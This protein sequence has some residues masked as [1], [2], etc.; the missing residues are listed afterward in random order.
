MLVNLCKKSRYETKCFNIDHIRTY[1]SSIDASLS[2]THEI[3]CN[4]RILILNFEMWHHTACIGKSCVFQPCAFQIGSCP[5]ISPCIG[6][7]SFHSISLCIWGKS[8]QL[9]NRF[10]HQLLWQQLFQLW[11]FR[12]QL[13]QQSTGWRMKAIVTFGAELMPRKVGRLLSNS[14]EV[15]EVTC[16]QSPPRGSMTTSRTGK[17]STQSGLEGLTKMRRVFGIGWTAPLF[18]IRHSQRGLTISP[19]MEEINIVWSSRLRGGMITFATSRTT[20]CAPRDCARQVFP[21]EHKWPH[22]GLP[23]MWGQTRSQL[24]DSIF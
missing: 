4:D 18:E 10:Q 23:Y 13:C 5:R 22:L 2:Y 17:V 24:P 14:A 21:I 8:F 19:A 7:R 1:G 11:S 12:M 3:Q 20:L 16:L 6:H 15:R 9:Q